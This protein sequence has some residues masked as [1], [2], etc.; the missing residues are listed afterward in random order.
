MQRWRPWRS[1]GAP[2]LLALLASTGCGGPQY[3]HDPRCV[4]D[5]QRSNDACLLEATTAVAVQ[6]CQ[7]RTS[8]CV[9][10]CG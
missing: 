1:A 5:C 2:L 9:H 8:A 6:A 10:W 3:V 4:N 7:E